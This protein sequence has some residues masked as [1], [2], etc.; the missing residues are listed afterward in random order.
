MSKLKHLNGWDIFDAGNTS[1]LNSWMKKGSKKSYTIRVEEPFTF[2]TNDQ[3]EFYKFKHFLLLAGAKYTTDVLEPSVV[4]GMMVKEGANPLLSLSFD[5]EDIKRHIKAWNDG[6]IKYKIWK[7][8]GGVTYVEFATEEDFLDARETSQ[9]L[10][11]LDKCERG[12]DGSIDM[13]GLGTAACRRMRPTDGMERY[14]KENI[15]PKPYK[16]V[17]CLECGE[18][19][20]DN[21]NYKIGHLYNKHNCKPSVGDY[22]AKQMLTKY[23]K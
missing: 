11:N 8:S 16:T 9:Q 1:A 19:V 3:E 10:L 4:P 14:V 15:L 2:K 6:F 22:K 18:E 12:K 20:C 5:S 7:E 23:F 17:K 21:L 13:A